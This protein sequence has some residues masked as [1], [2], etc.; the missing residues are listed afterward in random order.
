MKE[1]AGKQGGKQ[2]KPAN[3]TPPLTG[4]DKKRIIRNLIETGKKKV[5]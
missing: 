3:Q 1:E 5:S 4:E 2:N